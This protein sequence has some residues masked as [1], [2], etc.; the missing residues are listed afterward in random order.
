VAS[1]DSPTASRSGR[2]PL[3][4]ALIARALTTPLRRDVALMV[5]CFAILRAWAVI[6]LAPVRYSDTG[7]YFA[8]DFLGGADRLWTVP[9]LF[10]IF[11]TDG[12]RVA[13]HVLLAVA[14]WGTLAAVV[15]SQPRNA[16]LARV[17]AALVLLL[18]LAPQ[19]TAWDLV[20]LSESAGISLG[21][22]AAA[23]LLLAARRPTPRTLAFLLVALTLWQF[24][25]HVNV[26]VLL[27]ALT[28]GIAVAL[29][30]LER[31]Q[32]LVVA[33]LLLLMGLWG[34]VAIGQEN[35]VWKLNSYS[36]LTNR[37]LADPSAEAFFTARGLRVT[38]EMRHDVKDPRGAASPGFQDPAT[39]AYLE[40]HWRGS[41]LS[42]LVRHPLGSLRVPLEGAPDLLS[43]DAAL[44]KPR[45]VLP[46]T[47]Q[48]AA[49]FRSPGEVRFLIVAAAGL[50]LAA[51]WRRREVGAVDAAAAAIV[52]ACAVWYLLVW[53]LSAFELVRLTAPIATTLRIGLLVLALVAADRLMQRSRTA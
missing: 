38:D 29:W 35:D 17:G 31:P 19:V 33:A 3:P 43:A 51:W 40:E 46:G 11:P 4:R 27:A 18:G 49:S 6:G 28:I 9:V 39:H 13:A 7:T 21:A 22:L 53:H 16:I 1:V 8:I 44:A 34:T 42:W 23:A 15:A 36:I 14:S 48:E 10:T 26:L 32:S 30:R 5:A 47:L 2:R 25:R 45:P 20:M 37:M 52:A 50:W 12:L 24:A 41:Y